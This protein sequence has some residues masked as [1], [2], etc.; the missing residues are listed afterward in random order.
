[1][2]TK[3]QRAEATERVVKELVG[4]R[5]YQHGFKFPED[6]HVNGEMLSAAMSYINVAKQQIN[7]R[8]E[9]KLVEHGKKYKDA[10]SWVGGIDI[11][12]PHPSLWKDKPAT[13]P[14]DHNWAPDYPRYNLIRAA[15]LIVAELERLER[16]DKML[17]GKK[18][19]KKTA[20][21]LAKEA[22]ENI[23]PIDVSSVADA[24]A[25]QPASLGRGAPA[26]AA[27]P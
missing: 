10:T 11:G 9:N 1:M 18:E 4:H 19:K 20:K 12:Y 17:L 15:T 6:D 25:S 7:A 8:D 16:R 27:I 2:Q 3:A 22:A 23:Y 24:T 21:E 14:F 13:W 5:A 26:Y